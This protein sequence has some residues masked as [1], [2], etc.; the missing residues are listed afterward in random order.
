MLTLVNLL[1]F[2]HYNPRQ[3]D[4]FAVIYLPYM[5]AL[6]NTTK[7]RQ[8]FHIGFHV[9]RYKII[10]P[11]DLKSYKKNQFMYLLNIISYNDIIVSRTVSSMY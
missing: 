11:Y 4:N 1:I 9:R 5:H 7:Y 6:M 10:R 2:R 8:S 3:Y